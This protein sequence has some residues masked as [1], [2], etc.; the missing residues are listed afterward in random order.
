MCG[1]GAYFS[2]VRKRAE[3]L[4]RGRSVGWTRSAPRSLPTSR[5]STSSDGRLGASRGR[6]RT[7]EWC[8]VHV[9]ISLGIVPSISEQRYT[10]RVPGAAL[11]TRLPVY[12]TLCGAGLHFTKFS[13]RCMRARCSSRCRM[14][15][16]VGS[17]MVVATAST[18]SSSD[19]GGSSTLASSGSGP[20]AGVVLTVL[21]LDRRGKAGVRAALPPF[22]Q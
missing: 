12:L 2:G 10:P 14:D 19:W 3:L 16:I 13:C 8:G 6:R 22:F 17:R 4:S 1:N 20:L 15:S 7:F 21:G 18:R 5:A 11:R 9:L